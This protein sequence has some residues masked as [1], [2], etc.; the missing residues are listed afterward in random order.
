MTTR[1]GF[2]AIG[3]LPNVGKSTLLNRILGE[4]ISITSPKPQTTRRRVAGIW[5]HTDAQIVF[6]DTP[7]LLDPAYALQNAL[8]DEITKSM[9][10][11]DLVYLVRDVTGAVSLEPLEIAFLAAAR[12]APTFL[13]LN[14]TD[15]LPSERV[16]DV[17]A[18]TSRDARFADAQAVS[19]ATG[20][21]IQALLEA[22]RARLPEASF[23]FDPDQLTDRSLRFL[24]AELVRETL[25]EE[26]EQELPYASHVEVTT[27]DESRSIP[28]IE[29][30]IWVERDSQKGIVIG[31]G[32]ERLKR[33][34]VRSREKLEGLAGGQVFLH[35]RV[36]VRPNW[37]KKEGDLRRFGYR[38]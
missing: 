18:R 37:R 13:I 24:A 10:G 2:V 38:V 14:K 34:G 28:H 21:G 4:R 11:V 12:R 32:G 15:L 19:A 3:G 26:L 6:V 8:A 22:T 9:E 35:L 25:Y 20:R 30:V 36:K 33:I 16:T 29:A 23:F 31:R 7:G 1:A 27:Y 5:T 17:L